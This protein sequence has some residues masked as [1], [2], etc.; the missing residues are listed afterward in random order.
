MLFIAYSKF[1]LGSKIYDKRSGEQV[2][3]IYGVPFFCVRASLIYTYMCVCAL[4]KHYRGWLG[5]KNR[6]GSA[7]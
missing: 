2:F 4:A 7:N 1:E 5:V 6:G 3:K